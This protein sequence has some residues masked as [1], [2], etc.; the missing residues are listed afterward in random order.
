MT[1]KERSDLKVIALQTAILERK[2]DLKL[3]L[4][5]RS[6]EIYEWLLTA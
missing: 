4:L 5:E 3:N 1:Q 6:N 2:L